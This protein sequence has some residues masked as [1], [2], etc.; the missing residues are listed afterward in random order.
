MIELY[1][2]R[3]S[4]SISLDR[5]YSVVLD[6]FDCEDSLYAYYIVRSHRHLDI[7]IVE[8]L[9]DGAIDITDICIVFVG[10]TSKSSCR[11]LEFLIVLISD[12]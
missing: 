7:H 5:L 11:D 12:Q 10:H 9:T 3:K 4:L 1:R 2:I 6:F 8:P